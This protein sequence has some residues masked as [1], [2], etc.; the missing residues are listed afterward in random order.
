MTQPVEIL[1][2][3]PV[4]TVITWFPP[5]PDAPLP[6]CFSYCN[7]QTID[8]PDSPF[9]DKQVPDLTNR[10][11]L[12]AGGGIEPGA[13]GGQVDYNL[14]GWHSGPLNTGP[15]RASYFDNVQNNLILRETETSSWRYGLTEDNDEW[16]DGNH[17]H[18]LDF[19]VPA[20]GWV[21]LVYLI[22][23]K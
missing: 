14:Q 18:D 7:G 9:F 11:P 16:N 12:G 13:Y 2:A 5:Y 21:A 15:T 22:R 6:P 3:V 17:H 10:F 20:P 19:R 1:Y 4:G 23:I 8:D